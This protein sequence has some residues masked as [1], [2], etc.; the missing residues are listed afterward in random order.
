MRWIFLFLWSSQACW[1]L[2]SPSLEAAGKTGRSTHF[3]PNMGQVKGRTEWMAQA[4][5]ASVYITGAEVVF[6]LGNDNAHMKFAGA[7]AAKG[8]GVDP[9]GGYSNYF[10]GKTEKSWFT[11]VPHF[12]SVRYASV[13]PGIDVLYHSSEG[14]VEY[15]FVLAPGA[16]PNQIELAFDRDVH[17]DEQG[18]LVLSR[19]KQCR[20]RVMQD[21]H[22]VAS[23]YQLVS[24]RRVRIELAHYG[25]TRPLTI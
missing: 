25:R 5:G 10:L 1:L 9:S 8:T 23:E 11:G 6:A 13:Y 19:L 15:D 4:R 21:G 3:E 12:G 24:P 14:N 16:D 20:P 17:I 2:A 18:D 7:R 22:E